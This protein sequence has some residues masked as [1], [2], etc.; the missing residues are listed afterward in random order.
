ML[1]I[2][3][4]LIV[5]VIRDGARTIESEI[6]NLKNAFSDFSEI[7][8]LIIESDSDDNT[9]KKL[10]E[11][12]QS[13]KNFKYKS[14]GRLSQ[15]MPL[16]TERIAFCR[17]IYL[18]EIRINPVYSDFEYIAVADLDG[19]NNLLTQDSIRSCF[20]NDAW[21]VCTANQLGN[22]YDIWALR[23]A[24]WSPGDCWEQFRY[25]NQ[26][27]TSAQDSAN[28]MYA[29]VHS[30]MVIIPLDAEWIEVESAFG[31]LAI[32]KRETLL[33][34]NGKYIGLNKNGEEVVE[35][36]S[37]HLGITQNGFK[38]FINP[39]LINTDFT[40]HSIR[41]KPKAKSLLYV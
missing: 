34:S 4:I 38:I 33:E 39:R 8:W 16:R 20:S 7:H 10:S 17:N 9:I 5:G 19:V 24:I 3:K 6:F 29:T 18:D 11:F 31:G 23:H 30:K 27:A 37:L 32:Y 2:K 13:I 35:H 1:A 22:Y 14:A 28:L 21:D 15:E 26:F 40:E 12:S 25:L 36:I 41:F